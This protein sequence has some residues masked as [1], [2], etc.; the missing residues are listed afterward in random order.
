MLAAVIVLFAVADQ[1]QE[2]GGK[3][4]SV[5]NFQTMLIK[6]CTV[7]VPALG[8]T[9]IIIAG[10]ID[11]SVG[12][13][14]ALCATTLAWF[15]KY[16][17]PAAVAL[18]ACVAA[19]LACGVLNGA[20]V[21]L[22]RVVPFIVTLGTM[23]CFLGLGKYVAGESTVRPALDQ[24]PR[25]LRLLT[26]PLAEGLVLGFPI[27][28]WLALV[29]CATLA[30]ALRFTVFGRYVFALGSNESTAR[31]CGIPV[32][33]MKA[34]VYTLG[35]LFVGLG[36]IYQFSRLS[37]GNPTS[38]MGMELRIIAAVVIGGGSLSGGRGTVLGTAVGALLMS[39]I[40]SGCTML[41]ISNPAQDIIIGLIIVSAVTLDQ[42]RQRWARK[43]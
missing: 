17:Y 7:I 18:L 28:V 40:D 5:R 32:G 41:G 42:V 25:W 4:L 12:T 16:D 34:A 39:V 38:G 22:L 13:A 20:L 36:G 26:S 3:F 15:L 8:M 31:L 2:D 27:G 6:S 21:S 14:V 11:L 9:V 10:G 35:G 37:A 43:G 30:A 23:T 1:L 24:I 19:G 33:W 29:M